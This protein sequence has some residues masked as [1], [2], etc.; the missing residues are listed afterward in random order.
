[1]HSS[2]LI[3]YIICTTHSSLSSSLFYFKIIGT[4][5]SL[6]LLFETFWKGK[7]KEDVR[8]EI[9][10]WHRYVEALR[11]I[12]FIFG[13]QVVFFLLFRTLCIFVTFREKSDGEREIQN[14]TFSGWEVWVIPAVPPCKPCVKCCVVKPGPLSCSEDHTR[15]HV[16]T[17]IYTYIYTHTFATSID[18][19]AHVGTTKA[20]SFVTRSD[21]GPIVRKPT[22][23]DA[24]EKTF[25]FRLSHL[26]RTRRDILC[27]SHRGHRVVSLPSM[28]RE[29]DG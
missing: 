11:G 7:K 21:V 27:N 17:C 16:Y 15:S 14:V 12:R 23:F 28:T 24:H 19:C 1:M 18:V 13:N 29:A 8:R 5:F 6:L 10:S 22:V 2:S 3:K 26:M 20:S 25:I 9:R 4:F